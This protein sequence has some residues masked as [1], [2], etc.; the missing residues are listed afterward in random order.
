MNPDFAS[1]WISRSIAALTIA[2]LCVG[3]EGRFLSNR[4]SPDGTLHLGFQGKKASVHPN[5]RSGDNQLRKR[6]DNFLQVPLENMLTYYNIEVG[7]GTP[8]QQFNLLIDTG[9]S[10]L[11]VID[12]TNPYCSTSEADINSGSAI[13]CSVSGVFNSGDSSTFK[14]NNSDF[15]ISYGDN[16]VAEGDW[17]TD[18][19]HLQGQSINTMSFGLG[20]TTNSSIGILGIG[21][22]SNEATVSLDNPY[23][24]ENLPFRLR[25]EGIIKTA[26]YSLWLNDINSDEGN[27]LFGGV[28]HDKYSGSLVKL[29]TLKSSPSASSP[30]TFLI[31]FD[32]LTFNQ[33]G[34][35]EEMIT[36][37]ITALLDSGTS[38]SYFP[39]ALAETLLDSF[40]ASYS[41]SL[42]YYIQSCNLEGNLV[43]KFGTAEINVPFSSLLIPIQDRSSNPATLSNGDPAC[44]IGILPSSYKFALLGDTFMR[45]AYIVFDLQNDAI[46]LAQA[47]HNVTSSNVEV[48]QSTIPTTPANR[49]AASSGSASSSSSGSSQSTSGSDS[50]TSKDD[51]SAAI[52]LDVP[53]Y[54]LMS[55]VTMFCISTAVVLL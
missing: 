37:S 7:L 1:S 33:S 49:Q 2:S 11:W 40:N 41:S 55:V 22:M 9:S 52:T 10:D 27:I 16:T 29:P 21:Y 20:S 24:Y 54:A 38:L 45:N 6:A 23:T 18:T 14:K 47:I 53:Y 17:A 36:S 35:S 13:N 5:R 44:A 19:L 31:S 42:G 15:F 46:A 30:N 34:T 12:E 26:A 32:G 50:S 4:E 25:N 48:I 43:Y 39:T 8:A 51:S 3:T 28:D